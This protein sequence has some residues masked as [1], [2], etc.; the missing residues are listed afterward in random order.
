MSV[1]RQARMDAVRARI[2]EVI[3]TAKQHYNVDLSDV[4]VSYALRGKTAGWARGNHEVEFNVEMIYSPDERAFRHIVDAC[5]PH[6]F[7]HTICHR[8]PSLG[9]KHDHGWKRVCAR[10]GGTAARTHSIMDQPVAKGLSYI[11]TSTLG[12]RV[13][14]S[15]KKHQRVQLQGSVL[16]WRAKSGIGSIDKYCDYVVQN[17]HVVMKHVKAEPRPAGMPAPR[18]TP[19]RITGTRDRIINALFGM[20]GF[21]PKPLPPVA[22]Q[23]TAF[24]TSVR[25]PVTVS[26]GVSKAEQV[27]AQIRSAKLRGADQ[28]SVI[29]WAQHELGMSKGQAYRYVTENWPK[30]L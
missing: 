6:E 10:L 4:R 23:A 8:N 18:R 30:V 22:P 26:A 3:Q 13:T 11:Y 1:D 15:R 14:L 28:D 7:A 19:I 2:A 29:F 20:Q 25:G 24:R 16:N 12:K 17:G 21:T 5:V 9:R 27:R